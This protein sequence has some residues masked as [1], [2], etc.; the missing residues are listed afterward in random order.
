MPDDLACRRALRTAALGFVLLD[1]QGKPEPP[2][3]TMIKKW[4]D[5]WQ[6]LGHVVTGMNRQ[7]FRLHLTNVEGSVR[8]VTCITA[9]EDRSS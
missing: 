3:Q 4:L 6:G 5:N 8:W 1:T 9:W 2:E 7:G